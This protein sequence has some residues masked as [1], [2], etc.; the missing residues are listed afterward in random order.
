MSSCTRY[1]GTR[2]IDAILYKNRFKQFQ[3]TNCPFQIMFNVL[4]DN[5]NTFLRHKHAVTSLEALSFKMLSTEIMM[6]IEALFSSGLTP[7]QVYN[8]FLRNSQSNSADEQ[9]FHLKKADRCKC[10]RRRDF[11]SLYIKYCYEKFGGR[12]GAEMSDKFEERI[13]EFMESNEGAKISYQLCNKDQSS[14]LILAILIPLMQKSTF[15]RY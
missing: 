6:E 1:G 11:N 7:A 10:P 12:N 3:N 8:K 13:N 15:E 4:K 14:A 2:K 5:G 9:N